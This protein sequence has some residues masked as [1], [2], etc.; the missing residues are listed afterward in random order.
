MIAINLLPQELRPIQ[1]TPVP[2]IASLLVLA[3]VV[4]FVA[5][6]YIGLSTQKSAIESQ[7]AKVKK[8][9]SVLEA[10]VKEH[11]ELM[12]QKTSLQKRIAAIQ[13]ILKD[14]TVWSEQLHQLATLTPP[15]IWYK[16][17][18]VVNK[19]FMEE[20]PVLNKRTGK[21]ETDPKTGKPKMSRVQI[22]K[23]VLEISGYAIDDETGVSSTSTLAT[24]TTEDPA[25][26]SMFVMN[27]SKIVDTEFEDYPV[28]EFMFEY[29]IKN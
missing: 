12:Q 25:F 23:P 2:H 9:L 4:I 18:R 20:R 27:S 16:R 19:K 8:E 14:R 29:L 11:E 22:D 6:T 3:A 28:R 5:N 17:I 1:R 13:E 15:N 10:I 24:Q 26:S 7:I 21:P